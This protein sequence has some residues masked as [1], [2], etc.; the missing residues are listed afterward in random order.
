[1]VEAAGV[2]D[3]AP[4]G[5]AGVA[6]APRGRPLPTD[7]ASMAATASLALSGAFFG[8]GAAACTKRVDTRERSVR[9]VALGRRHRGAK[10]VA[11]DVEPVL[12]GVPL[13]FFFLCHEACQAIQVQ[14]GHTAAAARTSAGLGAA[15]AGTTVFLNSLSMKLLSA[16]AAVTGCAAP[17]IAAAAAPGAFAREAVAAAAAAAG[18][19]AAACESATARG[20]KP[21]LAAYNDLYDSTAKQ[22]IMCSG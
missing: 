14:G 17:A 21:G 3:A 6:A 15:E 18:A 10:I 8:A 19:A 2:V 20:S 16:A 12:A 5:L 13:G 7:L 4:P 1:M 11:C 9:G 22:I